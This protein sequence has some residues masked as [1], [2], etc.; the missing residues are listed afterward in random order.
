MLMVD[1]LLVHRTA[2]V[3]SIREATVESAIWTSIGL[4]F[5]VIMLVWQGGQASGVGC[6]TR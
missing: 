2:R 6:R 1:L 5:G 4:P 3:I